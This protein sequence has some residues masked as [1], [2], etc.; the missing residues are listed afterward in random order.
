MRTWLVLF[1]KEWLELLRS[2]RLIWLPISFLVL[3]VSQPITA[4][5]LPDILASSGGLPEDVV[6]SIPLPNASEVMAG[7][8]QQFGTIGLLLLAL[9]SMGA[10]SN[11]RASGT[12]AMI[13]VKPV[14]YLSFITAK[15]ASILAISWLSFAAGYV[16]S[17]YYTVTLFGSVGGPSVIAGLLYFGLW[18]SFVGTL[19]LLFSSLL[20]SPAAAAFGSLALAALLQ[21]A[22]SSLP[23]EQPWNPGRLSQLAAGGLDAALS[24]GGSAWLTVAVT[25]TAIAAALYLAARSL[26]GHSRS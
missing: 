20:S 16:A 21:V 12:A 15:W 23:F 18:L 14:S 9:S 22:A 8:L 6:R 11:E 5:F 25:A 24:D 26:Q 1:R 7:S 2:Y 19:A 3:G 10:V 13:L 4:Y 17:W